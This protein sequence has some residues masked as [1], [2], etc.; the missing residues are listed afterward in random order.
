[1]YICTFTHWIRNNFS[2]TVLHLFFSVTGNTYATADRLAQTCGACSK[3]VNWAWKYRQWHANFPASRPTQCAGWLL[4]SRSLLSLF[5][6]S[7]S[8]TLLL[9]RLAACWA[10]M[11]SS[12][13]LPGCLKLIQKNVERYTSKLNAHGTFWNLHIKINLKINI[14]ETSGLINFKFC[15]L[16]IF[17]SRI[18]SIKIIKFYHLIW[19]F[20]N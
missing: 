1:M 16:S 4:S 19:K 5:T 8:F 12:A 18:C 11:T 20:Q 7:S 2:N 13:C 10:P 15:I 6:F 9:V 3:R 17:K 14:S